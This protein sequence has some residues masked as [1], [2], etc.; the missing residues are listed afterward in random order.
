LANVLRGQGQLG[1]ETR[2]LYERYLAISIRNE[3][4][5]GLRT[6][7]GNYDLGLFHCELAGKQAKVDFKQTQLLLAKAYLEESVRIHTKIYGSTHTETVDAA[8]PLADVFSELSRISLAES[9]D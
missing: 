6:A 1:D 8:S 7:A 3:G 9:K 5:D 2:G 4:P